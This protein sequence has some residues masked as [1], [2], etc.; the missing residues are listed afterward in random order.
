MFVGSDYSQQE[1]RILAEISQDPVLI[2]NYNSGRDIYATLASMAY[3]LPYEQCTK[4]TPDGK[5]RRDH[6]KTLL[7]ALSYGMQAQSLSNSLGISLQEGQAL[8]ETF[9]ANLHVAFEYGDSVKRFCKLNGYIKTLWGR[10]RRF[11]DYQLPEFSVEGEIS[12][13]AKQEIIH[14]IR[15][16]RYNQ[17]WDLIQQIQQDHGMKIIIHD[18][19]RAI[20]DCETQILN[21]KVQGSA[22]EMTKLALIM[23]NYDKELLSIDARPV[24]AI[25]DELILEA[26][27]EYAERAKVRLE[28]IMIEAARQRVKSVSFKAEGEVMTFWHKD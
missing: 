1:P 26:P 6:G 13:K 17:R 21:S 18:N 12:S 19:T 20:R 10:K 11:P 15:R 2:D 9:R 5:V 7:L 4:D 3:K 8:F 24:L 23:C 27:I 14:R 22:A 28:E 16:A 25:H